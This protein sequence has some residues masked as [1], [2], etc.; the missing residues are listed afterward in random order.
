MSFYLG[1]LTDFISIYNN[2]YN[3]ISQEQKIIFNI[4]QNPLEYIHNNFYPK[5]IIYQDKKNKIIK[6]LC[7][8]S[9][10]FWKKNEIYIEHISSYKDEEKEN[11]FEKFIS[12]I[13]ENAFK[14]LG[15]DNNIKENDI[16]I[17][18]YYKS[19]EGKFNINEA[20]RDFF[21]NK[22]KFKWVKLE[23]ISKY[24]RYM[25]IRHH[26]GI[27]NENNLL[28]NEY[29]DNNILNQSILGKKE[30]NNLNNNESDNEESE[31]TDDINL[32]ISKAFEIQKD[33]ININNNLQEL[34]NFHK[35]K[36]I[37]NNFS[38]KNKTIIKFNNK[39]YENKNDSFI[40]I[41]YSNPFN[42][43]YLI[44]K[45]NHSENK[46]LKEIISFNIN[47]Y[48]SQ[49]DSEIINQSINK[50]KKIKLNLI[51]ENINYYSDITEL[52]KQIVNKFKINANINILPPFDNCISFIYNGYYYNRIEI[53]KIEIFIEKET[54]QIFYMI[55]KNENHAILISSDLNDNFIQKFINK[56]NNNNKDNISINFMNIYNNLINK[57][58]T[59][60][61]VLYIPSF[62]IKSK[63]GNNCYKKNEPNK[64]YNLYC[65][66]DYYN[67]KFFTEELSINKNINK[68]KI[69]NND[70]IKMNFNYDL[71]NDEIINQNTFIKN[72]FLLIAFDLNIMEHFRDFPLMTLYVTKD[73][74]IKI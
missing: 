65:Y 74:F 68:N 3:N 47:S 71:I 10:I 44:N 25:K 67:V 16:Y 13:K 17:D 61:N 20:I 28:N 8:I 43:V 12:F 7:I 9:H 42:F 52:N 45:V 63:I 58:N 62:E 36:N 51:P 14:I 39:I 32:D 41:K 50:F 40:N 46:N 55:S 18:L 1:K 29:D 69:R 48:F 49:N 60:N 73:N 19:E 26:F 30:F 37:L 22:L 6:G 34:N 35:I 64:T 4:K 56:E 33:K 2:Y 31:D 24:E 15:Y 57:D 72:N 54:E 38:I 66:E 5:I 21:R 59:N 23:N 53:K 11:I 70:C 27:N